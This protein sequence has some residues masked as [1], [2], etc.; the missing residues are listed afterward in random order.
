MKQQ[1]N[2]PPQQQR[3]NTEKIFSSCTPYKLSHLVKSNNYKD[4]S[5]NAKQS[6]QLT[7][8][9]ITINLTNNAADT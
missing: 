3:E 9:N 5:P 7:H 1:E 8:K 2:S 6:S 4:S